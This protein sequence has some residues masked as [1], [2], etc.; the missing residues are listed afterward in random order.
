MVFQKILKSL[1]GLPPRWRFTTRTV[2]IESA[3]FMGHM[4]DPL[5]LIYSALQVAADLRAIKLSRQYNTSRV[6]GSSQITAA[7]LGLIRGSPPPSSDPL[8]SISMH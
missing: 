2:D 4:I 1:I 7:C 8:P 5:L 6:F 3:S